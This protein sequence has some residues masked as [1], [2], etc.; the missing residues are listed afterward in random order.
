MDPSW[1][2]GVYAGDVPTDFDEVCKREDRRERISQYW[3]LLMY[4]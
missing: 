4:V 2:N 3:D 1:S